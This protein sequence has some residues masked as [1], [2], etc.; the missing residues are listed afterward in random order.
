MMIHYDLFIYN[1]PHSKV[2]KFNFKNNIHFAKNN[3]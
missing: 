3:N 2:P 1:V